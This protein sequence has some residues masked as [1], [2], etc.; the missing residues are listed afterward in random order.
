MAGGGCYQWWCVLL[1]PQISLKQESRIERLPKPQADF[2]RYQRNH[3][4][5]INF[6]YDLWGN[7][8]DFLTSSYLLS[9]KDCFLDRA[10]FTLLCTYMGDGLDHIDLP[11]PTIL[12]PVELWTGKQLFGVLV[13]AISAAQQ[14]TRWEVGSFGLL[15]CAKATL[16]RL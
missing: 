6:G 4:K 3:H 12:K 14:R 9:R 2:V 11:T 5:C 7:A 8:Q 10:T 16:F 15:E 13:R 1:N